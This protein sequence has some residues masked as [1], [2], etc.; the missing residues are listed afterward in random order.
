MPTVNLVK[1]KM[2]N[3][4]SNIKKS[5]A[6]LIGVGKREDDSEYMAISASDA[7][8]MK[9]A[10][11]NLPSFRN[12]ETKTLINEEAMR[13]GIIEQLDEYARVT[14]AQPCDL[15]IIY[16]SGHGCK[17]GAQYYL[18][19]RNTTSNDLEKTA[20]NGSL[21]VDKLKK[22]KCDKMLVL[23]DCCHASG[24][25]PSPERM[26][27]PFDE[28]TFFDQ[29]NRVIITACRKSQVSYL[30]NPV[31]IFTYAIIEGLGGKFLSANDKE[32]NVFN[33]AMDVRE[34]VV[35][36]SYAVLKV[37]DAQQPELN[38]VNNGATTN[39]MLALYPKGGPQKVS[40]FE[41]EFSSLKSYEGKEIN[42][43]TESEK[44]MSYRNQFN[45]MTTN[46]NSVREIGNGN[47]IFQGVNGNV[48][49]NSGASVEQ[50]KEI[51]NHFR[52]YVE[53]LV[54]ILKSKDDNNSKELLGKISSESF[55]KDLMED[56]D[57][58]GY[59]SVPGVL[60]RIKSSGLKFNN[61][62]F[63]DLERK[64]F[65][66]LVAYNPGNFIIQLKAFIVT[67]R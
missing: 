61:G 43:E 65:S 19:C 49:V 24:T 20:M 30:S 4:T 28:E 40:I 16:F 39:F 2:V 55:K 56:L 3:N 64:A 27:V 53:E 38:V 52:P 9:R 6:L 51:L 13:Q 62:S 44:D 35:A 67:L 50:I 54:T 5:Y 29:K 15:L 59:A 23:L 11:D 14:E 33:L 25:I 37:K 21:F 42:M 18:V 57:N 22:I 60:G 48:T 32:V 34:R 41:E 10:L 1:K 8:H 36:L 12:V 31:S 47:Y 63:S 45:W 17:S 66:D 26:P 58:N 46:V 7:E